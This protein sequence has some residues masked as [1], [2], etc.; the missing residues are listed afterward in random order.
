MIN[1][2]FIGIVSFISFIISYAF[3]PFIIRIATKHNL[4]T[5]PGGRRVHEKPT[6]Y[7]GGL[8]IYAAFT[9]SLLFAVLADKQL[10]ENFLNSAFTLFIAGTI[11]VILGVIDDIRDIKSL[12][13]L[14]GQ[15]AIAGFLYWQGFRIDVL[16]NPFSGSEMEIP[17]I[18]SVA[19]TSFWIVGMMNA[20]N[21]ID[22]LD[23][24]AAGITTIVCACLLF[25]AI[26][27]E[28]YV[29]AFIL[30]ALGAST[31]GFLPYNFYPAKIFLGDAGSMLIGVI[32]AVAALVG[33]QYKSTT[34]ATLLVPITALAIPISDTFFAVVRRFFNKRPIFRAD[35]K[36]LHHRLLGMGLPQRQIVLTIYMITLYLGIFAFLFVLIPNKYALILLVLLAL[37][38]F[39]AIRMFGFIE[40]KITLIYRLQERQRKR[41]SYGK[42]EDFDN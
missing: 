7:M 28:N 3:T 34:A 1:L 19:I 39:M 10:S 33:S 20:I 14:S 41:K 29:T 11:T 23:G 4:I 38:F 5:Y 18:I 31:L 32:L 42:D 17:R 22:G 21:L 40:R 15:I 2:K 27:L 26:F 13:K 24:L 8:V 12:L 36:H 9:L 6:P 25:S 16:T 35:K 30:V 37:G